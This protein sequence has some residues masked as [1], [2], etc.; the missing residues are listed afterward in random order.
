MYN[1]FTVFRFSHLLAFARTRLSKNLGIFKSRR[2]RDFDQKSRREN[3]I[4][5]LIKSLKKPYSSSLTLRLAIWEREWEWDYMQ[6]DSYTVL[7]PSMRE[8]LCLLYKYYLWS[9][10]WS[11]LPIF[12]VSKSRFLVGQS[13][14]ETETKNCTGLG[15]ISRPIGKSSP[16][17]AHTQNR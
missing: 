11:K 9:D 5:R 12:H 10:F 2:D 13:L 1:F 4:S 3:E 16:Q 8:G 6:K 15:E 7:L 14:G 17:S